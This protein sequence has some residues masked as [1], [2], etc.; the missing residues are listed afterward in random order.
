MLEMNKEVIT[1]YTLD[2]KRMKILWTLYLK[3][4]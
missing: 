2:V 4:L 1:S 3:T